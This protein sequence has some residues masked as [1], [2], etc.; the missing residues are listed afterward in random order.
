MPV[1]FACPG[2]TIRRVGEAMR[3]YTRLWLVVCV[4]LAAIGACLALVKSPVAVTF[5]FI[6]FGAIGMLLTLGLV[7]QHWECSSPGRMRLLAFGAAVGG[8]VG[9][10]FIG[11]ASVL[12]P[13]VFPLAVLILAGSP[14]AMRR[15]ARAAARARPHDASRPQPD[16]STLTDEQ[17]C[18]LWRASYLAL[19]NPSASP[20]CT[21]V[22]E[23]QR[24][25]DEFERRNR[26]GF[27]IWLASG[28][29]A[30]ASPLPY[31]VG[32]PTI[33]WDDLT[34]GQD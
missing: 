9:C 20:V 22:V 10:S 13:R 8:G 17:L 14:Y 33:N 18:Q 5:L 19:L 31:T 15:V 25:L 23:R 1:P 34:R 11:I 29:L 21:T 27:A 16:L 2:P 12:G 24:Y 30:S 32:V 26:S 28:P 7:A 6:C 4:P 3:L